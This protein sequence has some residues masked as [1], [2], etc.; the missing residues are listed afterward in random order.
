MQIELLLSVAAAALLLRNY[1]LR[2]EYFLLIC[3]FNSQQPWL[4]HPHVRA[5]FQP[6]LSMPERSH[7]IILI[8]L[9]VQFIPVFRII[10]TQSVQFWKLSNLSNADTISG[11]SVMGRIQKGAGAYGIHCN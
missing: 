2:R 5:S 8:A 4:P 9:H 6:A 10:A 3:P 7:A 11:G 1:M